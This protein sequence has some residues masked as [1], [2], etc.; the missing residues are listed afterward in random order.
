M[1][2]NFWLNFA[3]SS[4][5][6]PLVYAMMGSSKDVAVGTFA[7]ASL[8][9]G[10]MLGAVVNANENPKLHLQLALT[11]TFVAGVLQASLGI[12]RLINLQNF[13]HILINHNP[14]E[15]P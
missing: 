5:V 1:V 15:T 7:V 11:A 3:D 8:L 6:P 10:S 13:K 9:I 4:F 12:F 14:S 2:F